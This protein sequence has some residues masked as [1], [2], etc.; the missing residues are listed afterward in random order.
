M[1]F[2][3]NIKCD[4]C[5]AKVSPYLDQAPGKDAWKVDTTTADKILTVNDD[6]GLT[7]ADI[8]SQVEKAG[9]KATAI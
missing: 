8:I 1:Q 7:A 3:T 5:I 9:Y 2:K 6:K 4:A